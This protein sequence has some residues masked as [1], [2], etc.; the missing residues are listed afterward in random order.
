M[1]ILIKPDLVH[2]IKNNQIDAKTFK[3]SK[4]FYFHL[5]LSKNEA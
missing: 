4:Y 1:L 3:N 5:I 2:S